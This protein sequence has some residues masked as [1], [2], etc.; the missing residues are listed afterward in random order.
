MNPPLD[1]HLDPWLES[2]EQAVQ[3]GSAFSNSFPITDPATCNAI[4]QRYY[5]PVVLITDALCY[6]ATD[7]FVAGFR[8]HGIGTILGVDENTGAGGANVWTHRLLA[9]LAG[10]GG[11]PA[12][13]G[14]AALPRM[15]NISVAIRRMLRVGR[16]SGTILEDF[17][18]TPDVRHR[19]TRDDILHKNRDLL[20]AAGKLLAS[21]A[22]RVF[23]LS[24]TTDAAGGGPT[25]LRFKT[26]GLDRIDIYQGR[27]PLESIDLQ[28]PDGTVEL[29]ST[30]LAPSPVE[31]VG[32][33]GTERVAHRLVEIR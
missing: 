11:S 21:K 30:G 26:R 33:K 4:G 2:M 14:Y 13:T 1:L 16:Q 29:G 20:A 8:D 10:E 22:D 15:A 32:Y 6:S 19:M 3:T 9:K 5:G 7:I 25:T 18:I 23:G 24:A 28:E 27:R 31:L 17:G 12:R